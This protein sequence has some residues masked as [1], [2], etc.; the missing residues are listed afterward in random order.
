MPDKLGA[1]VSVPAPAIVSDP[2]SRAPKR[3]RDIRI[4]FER[5]RE[6]ERDTREKNS[7]GGVFERTLSMFYRSLLL[8]NVLKVLIMV[9]KDPQS[10]PKRGRKSYKIG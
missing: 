10:G 1:L 9:P 4:M 8:Y 3:E 6:R 7:F 2:E 5:E